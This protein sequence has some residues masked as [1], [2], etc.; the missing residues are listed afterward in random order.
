MQ[1]YCHDMA[2][3]PKDYITLRDSEKNYGEDY[4]SGART[5]FSR[6]A[7]D[8]QVELQKY[9]SINKGTVIVDS[10]VIG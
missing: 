5:K 4:N 1:L 2:G 7:V 10:V 8:P 6:V 9:I 3:S